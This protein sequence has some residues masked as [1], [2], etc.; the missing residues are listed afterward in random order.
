M[1]G[2]KPY[3]VVLLIGI[4]F[5]AT[6]FGLTTSL[7]SNAYSLS[8]SFSQ[9]PTM[10]IFKET[11]P[12]TNTPNSYTTHPPVKITTDTDLTAAAIS[13]TG[14]EINPYILGGWNITTEGIHGISIQNTTSYFIIRNCWIDTGQV[15][16]TYGI[17]IRNA[18]EQTVTIRDNY[19][20]NN[21]MGIRIENASSCSI[22]NNLC[23]H[24]GAFGIAIF[25]SEA[26]IVVNNLCHR[27]NFTYFLPRSSRDSRSW[28]F[29]FG[30]IYLYRS[31][32]SL[33]SNNTCTQ[34]LGDGII[35]QGAHYTLVTHNNCS[36][37]RIGIYIINLTGLTIQKNIC[38]QNNIGL[39]FWY[40]D[41]G[42]S[43]PP[44]NCT[45]I[46]NLFIENDGYGVKLCPLSNGQLFHNSFLMNNNRS[47]QAVDNGTNNQWFNVSTQEGNY[48]ENY[49]GIGEYP[50]AGSA[51]ATDPFPLAD[52]LDFD[53][54]GMSDGWEY[55]MG[56]N[57][58]LD[59]GTADLDSDELP[60]LW[61]YQMGLNATDPLDATL[62]PDGDG[63]T[64]FEEYRAGTDP[65]DADTDDDFFPDGLEQGWWGNPRKK[66]D[67]P[68]TRLLLL[69]SL[70]L[71][72]LGLWGG[73][74]AYKLPALHH[75]R[76]RQLQRLEQQAE[77]FHMDTRA[78]HA[79]DNLQEVEKAA[80]E[81]HHLFLD[82]TRTL[83][84]MRRHI[85]RKW[86]PPFLRPDLTPFETIVTS[87]TKTY[88]EFQQTRLLKV[89]EF[90]VHEGSFLAATEENSNNHH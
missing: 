73:L 44:Q 22:I 15:A 90:M 58:A 30:G 47:I 51:N 5:L 46:G 27:T 25:N 37:N 24:N 21:F 16:N 36:N 62:D 81:I 28:L 74:I 53:G 67:N 31:P 87:L 8:S 4:F 64:N 55:E 14:T 61:E 6:L 88:E 60:N 75:Q 9:E 78:F 38:H 32:F 65:Y 13:G 71:L 50:L 2:V 86:L 77:R 59:D 72:A 89:K 18:A 57:L 52:V 39:E 10:S 41:F 68:L 34:N 84:A 1:N 56:L 85:S 70:G 7:K 19:C 35:L 69:G 33:V 49:I 76:R 42:G 79:L 83:H 17:Y 43:Y 12:L 40:D 23:T 54:D 66:W 63:L 80:E 20:Q 48:W 11:M 3:S 82:C 26:I 29:L 45:L